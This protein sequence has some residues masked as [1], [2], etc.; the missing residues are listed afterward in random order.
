[1][2]ALDFSE[3]LLRLNKLDKDSARVKAKIER[4]E[5]YTNFSCCPQEKTKT[6]AQVS[7]VIDDIIKEYNLDCLAFRA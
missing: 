7:V 1:V 5:N 3:V 4:L 6:L 2:E